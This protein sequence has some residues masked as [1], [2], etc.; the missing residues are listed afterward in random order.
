MGQ[1]SCLLCVFLVY[2]A[3][4]TRLSA[5]GI[6]LLSPQLKPRRTCPPLSSPPHL[7]FQRKKEAQEDEANCPGLI[8]VQKA[9]DSR[10]VHSISGPPGPQGA[11]LPC[12]RMAGLSG[13]IINK[14]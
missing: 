2:K 6:C 12:K 11:F 14:T 3:L 1:G 7:L 8:Q 5:R 9:W 10:P 13:L 4:C